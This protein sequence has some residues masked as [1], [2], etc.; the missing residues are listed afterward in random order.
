MNRR[1]NWRG[2][3]LSVAAALL[4][5]VGLQ[6]ETFRVATYN[7]ENYLDRPT[8]TRPHP[9]SA[10][11]RAQVR[12]SILALQ[13]DVVALQEMGGVS[14]LDELRS[15]LKADGLVFPYWEHVTGFDTNS[16]VAVLSRFPFVSRRPHTND[17]FVL[18][19]RRFRVGR[20]V[21]EVDVRVN[22]NYSFTLITVHLKSRRPVPEADESEL[23][24]AEA[25]IVRRWIDAD[26]AAHPDLNLIVAGDLNDNQDSAPVKA[27]IGRGRQRLIDTRPVERN[28]G[29]GAKSRFERRTIAWTHHYGKEDSYHRIDYLLLSAGMAREWVAEESYVLAV[30]EWGIASDHRPLVAAFN[31]REE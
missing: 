26:L 7:L 12:A 6:A 5:T 18:S 23:R 25:K 15:S 3:L 1:E 8:A 16:H 30:P 24:L 29:R 17:T 4:G 14:A 9:K 28:G 22:P 2:C 11:S 31:D 10:E 20:G 13:P 21:A 27:V 19:G